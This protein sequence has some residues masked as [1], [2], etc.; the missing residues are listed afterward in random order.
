LIAVD[1]N[2]LLR[3]LL[4]DDV[5]QHGKAKALIETHPPVLLTDVVLVEAVWTLTGKRYD[6]DK[7]AICKVV[8]DL[9]G[10]AAF[11]FESSQVVWSALMD[12]QDSKPVR[13]KVLDF[14]DALIAR[15][16]HYVAAENGQELEGFYSFDK[17]VE[18]LEGALTPASS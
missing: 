1:T 8:R 9:I 15:K 4:A 6:L 14:A 11:R 7:E 3:Y 5:S 2:V 16:A 13:G 17:A 12:Y 10:D 18:Q